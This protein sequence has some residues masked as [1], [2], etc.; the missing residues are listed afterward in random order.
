LAS[1]AEEFATVRARF[2]A[3][4]SRVEDAD[5]ARRPSPA[6]WSVA[7]CVA[8]LNLTSAAMVPALQRAMAEAQT[9]PG[10][11]ARAYRGVAVGRLLAA[12]VGPVR[13]FAGFKL[14]KVA[15][16]PPFVP[17]SDLERALVCRAFHRWQEEELQLVRDAAGLAIDRVRIESP[18]AAGVFYDGYSA[19]LILARHE[20]RHLVQAERVVAALKG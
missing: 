11:G 3:L 13:L 17:G 4:E 7:E 8:H 10:V 12:M 1:V 15:T 19:L 2:A 20:L 16:P 5:W 9:Q 6:E 14:G 18:F